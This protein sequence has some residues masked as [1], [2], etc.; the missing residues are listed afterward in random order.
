MKVWRVQFACNINVENGECSNK[1]DRR[2]SSSVTTPATLLPASKRARLEE[3]QT[4]P[5]SSSNFDERKMDK[6]I[7]KHFLGMY[8]SHP[9]SYT[10]FSLHF[11]HIGLCI[12]FDLPRRLMGHAQRHIRKPMHSK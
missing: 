7:R 3:I 10:P 1:K 4:T 11:E 9:I 12:T 5:D 8:I 2:K 6:D